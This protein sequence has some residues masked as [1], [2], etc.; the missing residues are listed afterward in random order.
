MSVNKVILLGRVGKEPDVKV[1]NDSKV[2]KITLATSEKWKDKSGEPHEATE[3]HN[4]I[5]WRGL[6]EVIEKYVKKG[7]LLYIEGKIKTRSWESDGKK[8]YVT[9][10]M[11]DRLEMLGGKREEKEEPQ[12]SKLGHQGAQD[13]DTLPY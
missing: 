6:A 10:I 12:T 9:E 1:V 5:A 7:D 4:V 3:W 11:A 8:N 13:D 2:V